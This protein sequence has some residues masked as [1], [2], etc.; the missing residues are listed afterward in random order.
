MLDRYLTHGGCTHDDVRFIV[1]QILDL[2][3]QRGIAHQ[4][5]DQ[6]MSVQQ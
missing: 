1:E 2:V 4:P 5:P 6:H 3:G